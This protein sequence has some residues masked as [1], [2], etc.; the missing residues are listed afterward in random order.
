MLQAWNVSGSSPVEV[1]EILQFTLSFQPHWA[2]QF[3]QPLTEMSI[4]K[5]KKVLR[6][7]NAVVM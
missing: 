4:R 5:R 7:Q 2:L 6:E 3:S 1:I